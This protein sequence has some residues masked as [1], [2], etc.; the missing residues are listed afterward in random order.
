MRWQR[1]S[2][3]SA[4]NPRL[5]ASILHQL[6]VAP[7]ELSPQLAPELERIILKCL[8]KDPSRRFQ[9]AKE[10]AIDLDRCAHPTEPYA[11]RHVRAPLWQ[12]LLIPVRIHPFVISFSGLAMAML[13]LDLRL[14]DLLHCGTSPPQA[15]DDR[16]HPF[17][18]ISAMY[19]T[20]RYVC[21]HNTR[22]DGEAEQKG[23]FPCTRRPRVPIRGF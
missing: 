13:I 18:N 14:Q 6:V 19:I 11:P 16:V 23:H 4:R 7:R 2:G 5:L 15:S 17:D 20:Y 10:L 12:R 21:R 3:L 9:S 22:N 8:E 1:S